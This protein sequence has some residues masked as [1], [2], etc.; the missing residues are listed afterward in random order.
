[1]VCCES[2]SRLKLAPDLWPTQG[3]DMK[4]QGDTGLPASPFFVLL[5][6]GRC[7]CGQ[8]ELAA[9]DSTANG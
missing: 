9:L 7:E 1:M 8:D 4:P 3:L 2:R 6:K 5:V